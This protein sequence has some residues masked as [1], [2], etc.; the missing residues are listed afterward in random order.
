MPNLLSFTVNIEQ[1][2]V[3]I[4]QAQRST[5]RYCIAPHRNKQARSQRGELTACSQL[6]VQNI[7]QQC[8]SIDI[9]FV[10]VLAQCVASCQQQCSPE[11]LPVVFRVS[12][13]AAVQD[14]ELDT[15]HS[16]ML[17]DPL[18]SHVL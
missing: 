5:W 17:L 18:G 8:Q 12:T 16:L 7:V 6:A 14:V 1:G 4:V 2:V 3:S 13:A 10:D 15:Q 11:L 9:E